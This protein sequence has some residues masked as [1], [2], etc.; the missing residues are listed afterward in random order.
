ME[1]DLKKIKLDALYQKQES[2]ELRKKW[3]NFTDEDPIEKDLALSKYIKSKTKYLKLLALV[4]EIK[5][6]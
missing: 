4:E 2:D 1:N 5:R 3:Q 6:H